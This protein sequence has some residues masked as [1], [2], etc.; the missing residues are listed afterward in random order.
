MEGTTHSFEPLQSRDVQEGDGSKVQDHAV[1]VHSGDSDVG[2]KIYVPVDATRKV[3]E[4]NWQVQ[5]LRVTVI[6]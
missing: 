6:L 3:L 2:R 5:F 4:V 1:E